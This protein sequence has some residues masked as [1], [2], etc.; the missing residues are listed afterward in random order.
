MFIP[1]KTSVAAGA[2]GG[3]DDVRKAR[4]ETADVVR[5]LERLAAERVSQGLASRPAKSTRSPT[6]ARS[7]GASSPSGPGPA[8][9]SCLKGPPTK[10]ERL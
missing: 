3:I 2:A 4:P 5:Q 10:A 7:T 8:T 6:A 1:D 9:R